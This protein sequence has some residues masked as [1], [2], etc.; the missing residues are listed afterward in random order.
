VVRPQLAAV[1]FTENSHLVLP[2]LSYPGPFQP[3]PP[4]VFKS[5]DPAY[6]QAALKHAQELYALAN[7]MPT[8]STY[9]AEAWC[10]APGWT[11][12]SS[13][14]FDDLSLAASWLY[15]GTG[16]LLFVTNS[17]YGVWAGGKP[18]Q[19]AAVLCCAVCLVWVRAGTAVSEDAGQG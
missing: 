5:S 18:L 7:L 12:A 3:A 2:F 13:S 15:V 8:N 4:Q 11:W 6:A 1:C 9:C 16:E 19:C 17:A 10:G 14:V